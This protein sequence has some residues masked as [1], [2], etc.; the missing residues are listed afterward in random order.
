MGERSNTGRENVKRTKVMI[1]KDPVH[2]DLG[3]LAT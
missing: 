1:T 2:L 3:L